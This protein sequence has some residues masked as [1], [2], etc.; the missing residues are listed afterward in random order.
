MCGFC[1]MFMLQYVSFHPYNYVPL[2]ILNVMCVLFRT[3]KLV[4]IYF[5][6]Y[7]FTQLLA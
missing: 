3:S 1:V 2:L 6:V 7:K 4:Q 5:C